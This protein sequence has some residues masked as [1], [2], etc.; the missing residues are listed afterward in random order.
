MVLKTRGIKKKRSR[1]VNP[2]EHRSRRA[3]DWDCAQDPGD[4]DEA[5]RVSQAL[6][7]SAPRGS[8]SSKCT[9]SAKCRIRSQYL[10]EKHGELGCTSL[11]AR[12][13]CTFGAASPPEYSGR[14]LRNPSLRCEGSFEKQVTRSS[15][16]RRL[17]HLE[18]RVLPCT[19]EPLRILVQFVSSD[20]EVEGTMEVTL[21]QARNPKGRDWG[22]GTRK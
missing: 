5:A 7:T 20:N 19:D 14:R 10:A 2:A 12:P 1:P 15:L 4:L 22:K 9:Y 11:G 17:A 3:L 6:F 16:V 13:A 21:D 8:Q 18:E